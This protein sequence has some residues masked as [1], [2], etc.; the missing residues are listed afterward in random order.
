MQAQAADF[1]DYAGK[2]RWMHTACEIC[3]ARQLPNSYRI[4]FP[5][6]LL[7]PLIASDVID[8]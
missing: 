8:L 7:A 2:F 3:G 1:F 4:S 5:V 6:L